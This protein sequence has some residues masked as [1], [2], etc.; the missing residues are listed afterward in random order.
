LAGYLRHVRPDMPGRDQDEY[1][2]QFAVIARA[3]GADPVPETRAEAERIFRELRHDLA[4]SPQAREVAQLVLSQRPKG[5]PV[6]VQTML[7]AD[8]VAML[9]DWARSMLKLQRP[10]LTALPA[11]AATWGMGRTLRWAFRQT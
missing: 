5:T 4:T 9:P 6:A 7:T 3:L 11:R 8:A 1:Y 10:V 2:R